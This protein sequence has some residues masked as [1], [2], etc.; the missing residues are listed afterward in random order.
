M[1]VLVAYATRHGATAGIA[2]RIASVLRSAG[3][4]VHARAVRDV[5]DVEQYDAVVLGSAAYMFH[6]LK[7]A[8]KFAQRHRK[9]LASRPLWLFSSGPLGTETVDQDGNDVQQTSRPREFDKLER[10]LRPRDERVFFGA[11]DPDVPSASLSERLIRR[12][13]NARNAWPAG[14]FRDW[15][16]I[17]AWA[18]GIAA[19]L[20]F[21][22]TQALD[23]AESPGLGG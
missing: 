11:Y 17:D 19:D 5:K 15:P 10:Q 13:P 18:A 1:R 12:M 2:E 8:A 6:W 9:A 16:A 4:S 22:V 7:P 3:L 21:K 20:G 23:R 14:D